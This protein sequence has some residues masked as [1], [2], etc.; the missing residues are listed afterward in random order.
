MKKIEKIIYM[1]EEL[2][3]VKLNNGFTEFKFDIN[4][5]VNKESEEWCSMQISVKN[6]FFNYKNEGELLLFNEVEEIKNYLEQL[7]NGKLEEE[8]QLDFTEP[9]LEL[10]LYPSDNVEYI[11]LDIKFNLIEQGELS[12]DYYNLCLDKKEI[13]ELYSYLKEWIDENKK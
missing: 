8:E 1:W 7:L 10:N 4:R 11:L 12:A 9:D 2:M 13:D 5:I 6:E 3:D